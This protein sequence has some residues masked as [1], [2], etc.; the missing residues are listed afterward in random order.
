MC[1]QEW[2]IFYPAYGCSTCIRTLAKDIVSYTSSEDNWLL[3]PLNGGMLKHGLQVAKLVEM[4]SWELFS[5]SDALPLH[6]LDINIILLV[7]KVKKLTVFYLGVVL[8]FT[9]T[10]W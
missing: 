9:C 5:L 8:K 1:H 4:Q 2:H 7:T 10:T 6:K 3:P